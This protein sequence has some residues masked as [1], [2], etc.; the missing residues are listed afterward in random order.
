[1]QVPCFEP[2]S[3][4]NWNQERGINIDL[5]FLVADI[6]LYALLIVF[7]DLDGVARIRSMIQS[8]VA[9][10]SDDIV[11]DDDVLKER[12]HVQEA[13]RSG[14]HSTDIMLVDA[15]EKR[16]GNLKAVNKLNFGVRKGE[17][18]GLLG[19]NGAGKTTTF[20]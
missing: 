6:I 18:F 10:E 3:F 9:E 12:N 17:C 7:I 20:R 15:L 13:M 11:E 1:M 16:F 14:N 8:K 19:V 5:M 2:E 4:Y